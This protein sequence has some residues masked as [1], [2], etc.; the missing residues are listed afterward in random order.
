M[1]SPSQT[2]KVPPRVIEGRSPDGASSRAAALAATAATSIAALIALASLALAPVGAAQ[3]VGPETGVVVGAV[4]AVAP[5]VAVA[6]LAIL[7]VIARPALAGALTAG[8]GA[9]SVGLV[10]LDLGLVSSPIDANRLEL[11]RPTTAEALEPELGAY[12]LIAA[13]ALAVVGGVLGLVA[14]GRASFDDGYGHSPRAELT[15]RSSAVRIGATLSVIA[16]VAS[17]VAAAAMWTPP[18]VS[19]DSIVLVRAVVESPLTTA[20]GSGALALAVV[21]VVAAALASISPPVAAGAVLAA[22]LGIVGIFGSRGVAGSA[23]GPGVDAS[24]GSWIGAVGGIVLT[25]VGVL[26]L[27]ISAVRDRRGD[28]GGTTG[29]D[30]KLQDPSSS[31]RWHVVAGMSGV[32]GGVLLSAAGFLPIL[33]VPDGMPNPTILAT[34]TALI[35]GFLLVIASVPMFFSLFAGTVRPAL[36]IIAVAAIMASTGVLQSVVLAADID[37]IGLGIGGI[38]TALGATAAAVC[39]LGVLLAGSSERDDVDTSDMRTDGNVGSVAWLGGIVSAVALGLPLYRGVDT[40]A[41]SF[42]E[43]PWG[44]DAWGQAA[45]AVTVVVAVL[46]ASRSRPARGTAL[47]VGCAVA[48]V[49]YVLGWPLTQARVLDPAIGAGSF[50]GALGCVI[51]AVAAALSARRRSQ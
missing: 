13:H 10:L 46:L 7:T 9:I 35:A 4:V 32:A 14:V 23:S 2:G 50:V 45:M 39:G 20:L 19:T 16:V 37:G 33:D 3:G 21:I 34:R 47:L 22:G 24:A 36:G 11:F 41:A 48:M 29:R 1:S 5:V 15:G 6:I 12:G 38:A 8:Y 26:A 30:R 28:A 51:L 18:Y 43:F 44:W 42:A 27:P 40:S 17:L 31:M 49:V 25:V